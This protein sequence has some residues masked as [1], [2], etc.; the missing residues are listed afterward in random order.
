MPDPGKK[1]HG[2]KIPVDMPPVTPQRDVHI[3]PEPG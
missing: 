1:K 3:I 2:G